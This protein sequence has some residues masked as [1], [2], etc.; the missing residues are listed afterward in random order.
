M[1]QGETGKSATMTQPVDMVAGLGIPCKFRA[2][3]SAHIFRP[4][5]LTNGFTEFVGQW[6]SVVEKVNMGKEKG[7]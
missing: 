6:Y 4:V 1:S 7:M 2:E 3:V 5:N